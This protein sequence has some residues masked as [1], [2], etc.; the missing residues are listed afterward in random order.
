[1]YGGNKD[2]FEI[3][4][5]SN[6]SIYKLS[7]IKKP[8]NNVES[9]KKFRGNH[10]PLN[11]GRVKLPPPKDSVINNG[12]FKI[13]LDNKKPPQ[14]NLSSEAYELNDNV[15]YPQSNLTYNSQ[16]NKTQNVP[17]FRYSSSSNNY[18]LPTIKSSNTGIINSLVN[19]LPSILKPSPPVLYAPPAP[20]HVPLPIP[21]APPIPLPIPPAPPIPL[22]IIPPNQAPAQQAPA[23][24]ILNPPNQAPAQQAPAQQILNLPNQ[25]PAQQAPAQQILNPPNQAP[26]QQAPH[27][28]PQQAQQALAQQQAQ[29][30]LAQQQAQQALAQQQAQQALAQQALAQQQIINN[31]VA[32]EHKAKLE[33]ANSQQLLIDA[34]SQKL[35]SNISQYTQ[36]AIT[37][38]P[39]QNIKK[40]DDELKK[41]KVFAATAL[42]NISKKK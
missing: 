28:T 5:E 22:P 41:L 2:A 3:N 18:L 38:D 25:A 11:I 8:E 27:Q 16:S 35:L 14:N 32:F 39:V 12:K 10:I 34:N 9:N 26:A 31:L 29:Q 17:L 1:M 15:S 40:A 24:Q 30:A 19:L 20:A 6:N 23:Q 21:P 36:Q 33:I 42:N 7:E 13:N 37:K 4:L